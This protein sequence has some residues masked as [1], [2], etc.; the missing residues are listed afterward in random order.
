MEGPLWTICRTFTQFSLLNL[1][2]LKMCRTFDHLNRWDKYR[3]VLTVQFPLINQVVKKMSVYLK[4]ATERV[5]DVAVDLEM[6]ELNQHECMATMTARRGHMQRNNIPPKVGQVGVT[7]WKWHVLKRSNGK[8]RMNRSMIIY[9]LL[10]TVVTLSQTMVLQNVYHIWFLLKHAMCKA[11]RLL[12]F[13]LCTNVTLYIFC[14]V[15]KCSQWTPTLDEIS[16]WEVGEPSNS[17]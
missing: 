17:T 6:D 14:L 10:V 5:E 13:F 9:V 12:F 1:N 4:E 15:G 16:A 8:N 3:K 11:Q 7:G 2:E